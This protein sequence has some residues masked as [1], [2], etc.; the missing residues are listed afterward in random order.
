[1]LVRG[2]GSFPS[3]NVALANCHPEGESSP[4]HTSHSSVTAITDFRP[5]TFDHVLS[6]RARD[7]TIA[8]ICWQGFGLR[9]ISD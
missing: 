5:V 6:R 8:F 2:S 1:M 3:T 9:P 7:P 4:R